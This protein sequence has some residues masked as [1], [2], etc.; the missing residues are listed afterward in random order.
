VTA[1]GGTASF[2][3]HPGTAS[4]R[5]YRV[6]LLSTVTPQIPLVVV[7]DDASRVYG[8]ANPAFS[9]TITG[10]QNAA[11][12]ICPRNFEQVKGTFGD[13]ASNPGSGQ[14]VEGFVVGPGAGLTEAQVIAHCKSRIEWARVPP[15]VAFKNGLPE[16]PLGKIRRMDLC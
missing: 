5:F 4:Q 11:F 2:T 13:L 6:V 15:Y 1:T 7:A 8:G 14:P 10:A 16:I 12:I 9:G 3:D